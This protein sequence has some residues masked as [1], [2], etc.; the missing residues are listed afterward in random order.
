MKSA[1]ISEVA[2]VRI[3]AVHGNVPIDRDSIQMLTMAMLALVLG[4]LWCSLGEMTRAV[5]RRNALPQF[6]LAD[7]LSLTVIIALA[8]SSVR[9]YQLMLNPTTT[10]I[11]ILLGGIA[12]L[13]SLYLL[14][15]AAVGR[16]L[17]RFVFAAVLPLSVAV[18]GMWLVV[19]NWVFAVIQGDEEISWQQPI[20]LTA[21]IIVATLFIRRINDWVASVDSHYQ[22]TIP[23]RVKQVD[24]PDLSSEQ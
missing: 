22:S 16:P 4:S 20:L 12:W 5:S 3:F 19:G 21:I 2:F 13:L 1:W 8:F 7:G 9:N 6:Q 18:A 15:C 24:K 14:S 23:A 11:V 10:M 17:K